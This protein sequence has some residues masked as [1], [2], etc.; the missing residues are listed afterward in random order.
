MDWDRAFRFPLALLAG[1]CG[2][3]VADT[4]WFLI[5]RRYGHGVMRLICK[6]SLEPTSCARRTQDFVALHPFSALTI[7]K[8]V[9]GFSTLAPPVA[10]QSKMRLRQFLIFDGIGSALWVGS[11]LTVGY[12]GRDMLTRVPGLLHWMERFSGAL[13]IIFILALLIWRAVRHRLALRQLAAARVEPEEVK[14]LLDAGD[15]VTIVDLRHPL[16]VFAEPFTLPGALRLSPE[17]LATGH[18]VIP[19]DREIVLYCTCPSEATSA[20]TAFSLQKLGIERVHPLRGGY[21]E[22]KRLGFPLEEVL[23]AKL[24]EL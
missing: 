20:K 18:H 4:A 14:R 2:A 7:A 10:G 13:L 19:R 9:P 1:L 22:W 12:L 24:S 5:G 21:D 16:D 6:L 17:A 3:L 23:P 11:L 8:F 15:E